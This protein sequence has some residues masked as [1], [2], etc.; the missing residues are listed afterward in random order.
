MLKNY[1]IFLINK[2]G[3]EI[4]RIQKLSDSP[5]HFYYN[6]IDDELFGIVESKKDIWIIIL[7]SKKDTSFK[8]TH[9]T[10]N[11]KRFYKND[12][13][14]NIS[15]KSFRK[16]INNGLYMNIESGK[17]SWNNLCTIQRLTCCLR[18][19]IL[20]KEVNHLDENPLNNKIT[21]LDPQDPI[22]HREI[23]NYNRM[24]RRLCETYITL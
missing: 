12:L 20:N 9:S 24:I 21:N 22:K 16:L 6:F 13:K 3:K 11:Y 18:E 17:N 14:N 19:N 10:T 7:N 23:T 4:N 2:I 5:S 8:L 15:P 1:K